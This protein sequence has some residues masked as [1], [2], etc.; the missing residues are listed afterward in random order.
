MSFSSVYSQTQ[1]G[2]VK[3]KGRL[4]NNETVIAGS[5]LPGTMVQVK[6]SNTVVSSN[7]GTFTLVLPGNSYYL[8]SV[9][10]QGY[11]LTDPDVLSKQYAYSKNP[12]VLVLET[13]S[14]QA[15]DKLAVEKKI[16]R[17]LQRQLQ[18]KEDEIEALKEQNKLSDEAYRKQL[19]ELYAQ[20]ESNENLISEMADRYSRMDFDEVNEFNRRISDLILNGKLTEADSLL[21]TKG[22]IN[23]RAETLR[24]HQEANALVEQELKKKQKKLEK[25]KA[26]T[27]KE[28]E[29]LAQDCY[30]KFE[31]FKIQHLNDSAAY[32][33]EFRAKLDTMT[34]EWQRDAASYVLNYIGNYELAKSYSIRALNLSEYHNQDNVLIGECHNDIGNAF[35]HQGDYKKA[36]KHYGKALE[37]FKKNLGENHVNVATSYSNIG[38][39]YYSMG[40]YQKALEYLEK[41]LSIWLA[42]YGEEHPDVGLT[43]NNIGFL[44]EDLDNSEKALECYKKALDIRIKTLG[45]TH[46]D[47]AE[48]YNNLGGYYDNQGDTA[49]AL[50]YYNKALEIWSATLSPEHPQIATS[51][52]NLGY[53]YSN[54]GNF[55]MALEY[56]EKSLNQ[57]KLGYGELHPKVAQAYRNLGSLYEEQKQYGT[58]LEYDMKALDIQ[59][60]MLDEQHPEKAITYNNLGSVY[61][62]LKNI[63]KALDCYKK[64]ISIWHHSFGDKHRML[65]AGYANIGVMYAQEESYC[66]L[67]QMGIQ[68]F[69]LFEKEYQR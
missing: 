51:Y 47:V 27:Q 64:A 60:L 18:E 16:R 21:N 4:G 14:Q 50:K 26:L 68:T 33:V 37:M 31:I 29:D 36:I 35:H 11:I 17:T 52:N 8:Q 28:L 56:Y 48:T 67:F 7:N 53:L 62:G 22:D 15:D 54:A 69:R 41:A 30:S 38:I 13:P 55:E 63:S 59:N 46:P 58:A 24:Q 20:Q 10:K 42:V 61:K 19:Q 34:V 5:R 1:H 43:Y 6:G 32:Y 39:Y 57:K 23:S 3:T 45:E 9:Q 40:D 44:N 66:Q 49:K 2:Y 25:S 65:G 12:L